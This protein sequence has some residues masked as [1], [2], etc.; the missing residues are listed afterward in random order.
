MTTHIKEQTMSKIK[1]H[2]IYALGYTINTDEDD[3]NAPI[4]IFYYIGHTDNPDRRLAEHDSNSRNPNH[5]E[6]DTLKYRWTRRLAEDG[7]DF[8]MLVIE[9]LHNR[10]QDGEFEW[11]L[12]AARENKK[13]GR[14]F[15]GLP[16]TN[17][18]AGDFTS[19]IMDHDLIRSRKQIKEYREFKEARAR[20]I[21][22][23]RIELSRPRSQVARDILET[24]RSIGETNA[25]NEAM[26]RVRADAREAKRVADVAARTER[27]RI[28]A[29]ER[30]QREID[31][32]KWN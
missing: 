31:D 30:I 32:T 22:L 26:K 8:W 13:D 5:A 28:E 20:E 27:L 7:I 12:K 21:E 23:E 17:M 16:L 29:E 19:E 24:M 9:T 6:Y 18:K 10:E 25:V 15:F 4:D 1:P 3:N 11:I 2:F 14:F